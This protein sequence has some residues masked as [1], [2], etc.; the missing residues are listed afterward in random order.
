MTNIL[1]IVGAIVLYA[2]TSLTT[3]LCGRILIGCAVAV[4]G[5][6]DV[7]YLHEIS[8]SQYRGAIVSCNEASISLGFLISYL[9]G[10]FISVAIPNEGWRSMFVL[11]GT[12]ASLQLLGMLTMPESPIW[13]KEKG[14]LEA[15]ENAL[16]RIY[17]GEENRPDEDDSLAH[18][19]SKDV[20]ETIATAQYSSINIEQPMDRHNRLNTV[21]TF[22]RQII[23]AVFLCTMQNWCGHPNVLNFA[24]ELFAQF[25]F[26]SDN[27]TLICTVLMGL[28]SVPPCVFIITF[29]KG[30]LIA[31]AHVF[32]FLT[33]SQVKFGTVC[34]AILKVDIYGRRRL[35]LLGMIIIAIGLFLLSLSFQLFAN[36]DGM[37][38]PGKIISIIAVFGIAGGYS[39]SFG[40]LT[41]LIISEIFPSSIRGRALGFSTVCSYVAAALVSFTFYTSE[42]FALIFGMYFLV[43]AFSIVFAFNLIPDTAKK[44][45]VEIHSDLGRIWNESFCSPS[46]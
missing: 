42:G 8:P 27:H 24:P 22:Y 6:A 10:Y 7:A 36:E 32:N 5:I 46:I 40:P 14:Y 19:D 21:R 30:I 15:S 9:M 17:G 37:S 28:V 12:V 41:W 3:V 33:K 18:S 20:E 11:G 44:T 13:L 39:L 26:D 34:F 31:Q 25:G 23:I 4:S 16:N 2:A 43:T 38:I 35:L 45:P 1:F 29:R